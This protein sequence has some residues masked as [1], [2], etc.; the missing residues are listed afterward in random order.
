MNTHSDTKEEQFYE[1]QLLAKRVSREARLQELVDQSA[2]NYLYGSSTLSTVL[3]LTA[4][5]LG[6]FLYVYI[7]AAEE[8][9]FWPLATLACLIEAVRA[10]K[11]VTAINE[12]MK[13]SQHDQENRPS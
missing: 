8:L 13:L 1:A 9:G 7:G 4:L 5:L 3:R 12:L 6:V 10:N 2:F 11:R